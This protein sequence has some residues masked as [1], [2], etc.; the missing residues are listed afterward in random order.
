[1]SFFILGSDEFDTFVLNFATLVF[2]PAALVSWF[3]KQARL[4]KSPTRNNILNQRAPGLYFSDDGRTKM[5][6]N[7]I[8]VVVLMG[9]FYSMNIRP[10]IFNVSS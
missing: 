10:Y 6:Y 4:K 2:S 3:G 1:V 8:S 9:Y 7:Q 5:K